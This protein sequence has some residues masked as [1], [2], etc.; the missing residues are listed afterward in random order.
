M[1][2]HFTFRME[3]LRRSSHGQ[4]SMTTATTD[5]TAPLPGFQQMALLLALGWSLTNIAYAIY[6]LPLTFV[7]KDEL[8]LNPQQIS[9]FFAIGVFSNYLKPAAGILV[10]SVPLF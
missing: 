9:T 2:D 4:I 10:D 8:R 3:G 7:L 5:R 1:K 6:D